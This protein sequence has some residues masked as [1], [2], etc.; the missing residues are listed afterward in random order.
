MDLE[1]P[2]T[3]LPF[4]ETNK[5]CHKFWRLNKVVSFVFVK[6]VYLVLNF[7][8]RSFPVKLIRKEPQ[9]SEQKLLV[10]TMCN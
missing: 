5:M 3:N 7:I 6:N 2:A 8:D 9:L 4:E 10:F 1:I